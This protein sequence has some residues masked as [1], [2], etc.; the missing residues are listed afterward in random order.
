MAIDSISVANIPF[1]NTLPMGITNFGGDTQVFTIDPMSTA[2]IGC[3]LNPQGQALV[4]GAYNQ[5]LLNNWGFTPTTNNPF[6]DNMYRTGDQVSAGLASQTI[7]RNLQT[8][9]MAKQRLDA[10]LMSGQYTEKQ[11]DQ[12][13]KLIERLT[14]EETKL[15]DLAA[16]TDLS[17]PELYKKAAAIEKNVRAIIADISRVGNGKAPKGADSSS[18]SSSSSSDDNGVDPANDE[19][20]DGIAD[21]ATFSDEALLMA[22]QLYNAMEGP[23]TNDEAFEEVCQNITPENVIDVMLAYNEMHSAEHGETLMHAFMYDATREQKIQFGRHI[24]NALLIRARQAG[25]LHKCKED[26]AAIDREMNSWVY[27][28]NDVYKNYDNIIKII[29]EAEGQPYDTATK[30]DGG[31]KKNSKDY[32]GI[33]LSTGTGAA[34]GAAIGSVVPGIG[35][36]IGAGVGAVAGLIKGIFWG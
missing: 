25:V 16:E 3:M 22:D 6:I 35:T 4:N 32:T 30:D 23:G 14:E 34:A 24:K 10:M 12:I 28:N 15:N 29:A 33:A 1:W 8:I 27:V 13:N 19:D 36:A 11:K 7:N 31:N 9:S 26:F 2:P 5:P 21:Y 17:A 18:S 20:G